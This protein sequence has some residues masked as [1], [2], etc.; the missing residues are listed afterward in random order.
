MKVRG[1]FLSRLSSLPSR[2]SQRDKE[3]RVY[4]LPVETSQVDL[5]RP[6]TL[7]MEKKI[8]RKGA[9]N[10]V[11]LFYLEKVLLLTILVVHI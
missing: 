8:V 9:F 7:P 1:I 10:R 2:K 3:D 11:R 4:S 5:T 6:E